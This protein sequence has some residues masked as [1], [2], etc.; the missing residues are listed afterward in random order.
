MKPQKL[1]KNK[2]SVCSFNQEPIFTVAAGFLKINPF[3]MAHTK[4]QTFAPKNSQL[5]NLPKQIY[6]Y[7]NTQ[8]PHPT[9][10]ALT[11]KSRRPS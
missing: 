8:R 2:V 5:M 11:E 3:A 9:A 10:T 7:A 6:A 1:L 4:A